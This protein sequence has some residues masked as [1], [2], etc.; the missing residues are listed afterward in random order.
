MATNSDSQCYFIQLQ[1]DSYLD[2]DLSQ[3]QQ[4]VFMTHVHE[5][6]QCAA[7]LRYAQTIQDCVIDLPKFDCNDQ[8]LEPVYRLLPEGEPGAVKRA[9][10][11][12]WIASLSPTW[13]YALPALAAIALVAV[14]VSQQLGFGTDDAIVADARDQEYSPEEVQTALRELNMAIDYLNEVSQRTEVMIGDRFLVQ[15]IRE[16]LNASFEEALHSQGEALDNDPI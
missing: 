2:G 3:P 12:Q 15:P 5:C 4:D 11:R 16:S 14:M 13:S 9:S 8:A 10:W 1:I 6:A 7:E